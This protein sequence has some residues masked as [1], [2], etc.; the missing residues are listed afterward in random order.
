MR[1][2]E[3]IPHGAYKITLFSTERDFIVKLEAGPMEQSYKLDKDLFESPAMVK[4]YLSADFLDKAHD[5]F[6]E[7]YLNRQQMVDNLKSKNA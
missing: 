6:N 5:L 7:M 2:V 4:E 3:N 1:I